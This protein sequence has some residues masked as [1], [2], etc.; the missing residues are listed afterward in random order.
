VLSPFGS[1]D[2]AGAERFSQEQ[3]KDVKL[4]ITQPVDRLQQSA[5]AGGNVSSIWR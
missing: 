2:P 3:N 1:A 5:T 4:P